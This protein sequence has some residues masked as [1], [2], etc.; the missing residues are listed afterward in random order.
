MYADDLLLLSISM[1]EL[2]LMVNMHVCLAELT[3][4]GLEI[5]IKKS[6]CVRVGPRYKSRV[7]PLQLLSVTIV[8]CGQMILNSWE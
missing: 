8:L 5:N 1:Q 6:E 3:A 7:L 2:Q 4:L